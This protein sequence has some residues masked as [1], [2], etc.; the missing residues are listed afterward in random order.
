MPYKLGIKLSQEVRSDLFS[1]YLLLIIYVYPDEIEGSVNKM[2]FSIEIPL[3]ILK[4][5]D[6]VLCDYEAKYGII[7]LE[8]L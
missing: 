6:Q 2:I 4:K 5:G 8:C 3:L 1:N 7:L